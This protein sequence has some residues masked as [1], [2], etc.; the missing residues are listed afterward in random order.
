MKKIILSMILVGLL[1]IACTPA[2]PPVP[3]TEEAINREAELLI[4]ASLTDR[5][6]ADNETFYRDQT[7]QLLEDMGKSPA[8]AEAM[9]EKVLAPLVAT[10]HQRLVDALVPI[11]RRYYS[12]AEIHQ[13][14]S[15]YRTEVARKSM[16]VS[17][18]IAADVQDYAR[19][20]G[21]HFGE[22]LLKRMEDLMCE[23][24]GTAPGSVKP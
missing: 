23:E 4:R 2:P 24:G 18:R 1:G 6:M 12:A 7:R 22:E 8:E 11:F 15:F 21:G 14:L 5:L 9:V 17:P 20:W 3:T 16:E 13:L 19:Q 10:E